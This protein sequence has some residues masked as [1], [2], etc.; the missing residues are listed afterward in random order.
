ML[1]H[2]VELFC[3]LRPGICL[4]QGMVDGLPGLDTLGGREGG[5]EREGSHSVRDH[6]VPANN[7]S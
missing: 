4:Q 2:C 7:V 1:T 3:S 5:R 6:S